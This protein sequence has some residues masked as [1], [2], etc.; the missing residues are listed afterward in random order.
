MSDGDRSPLARPRMAAGGNGGDPG[1]PPR[2]SAARQG[3]EAAH[4]AEAN[5]LLR[6]LPVEEYARMAPH[7]T[8]VRL[9]LREVLV[10][11]DE[12]ITDVYF[13]RE[14]VLSMIATEQ[15]GGSVEVGTIGNE[16]FLGLAV[17]FGAD[18]V[19]TRTF[20]QIEGDAWRMR[21]DEFRRVVDE[22]P[23]VRKLLLRYAQYF[24]DQLSQSVACNRIHT[25]EERCA[26][27]LLMSHDRVHGDT[28]E[29]TH[30]FLSLMLGV[31]R[32]GVT[33]AMGVL[34]GAEILRYLR[35]RITIVDRPR[36]EEASCACYHITRASQDRL[37][38]PP[39]GAD[40]RGGRAV[41]G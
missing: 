9:Q 34:Q 17:L 6:M 41:G 11:A 36:L 3:I 19:P 2:S 20:A 22:R 24:T 39:P 13:P 37:L 1:R 25:L 15:E 31:R 16:G 21:A 7:F 28:F 35:G 8:A 12:P 18:V 4:A 26:R 23:V 27:W 40:G 5:R 10:E 30:E 33:V 29:L 32:A 38:G 14:G